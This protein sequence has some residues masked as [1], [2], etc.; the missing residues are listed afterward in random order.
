[1]F[2][3]NRIKEEYWTNLSIGGNDIEFIY[4]FLLEKEIP[5]PTENVLKSLIKY[6]ISH[7]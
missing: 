7:E 6:R 4:N 1:M 2:P 3:S 5:L